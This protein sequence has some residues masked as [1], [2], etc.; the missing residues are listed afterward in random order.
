[1]PGFRLILLYT[2]LSILLSA[3]SAAE[4]CRSV[5]QLEQQ[6]AR[7]RYQTPIQQRVEQFNQFLTSLA[8]NQSC[9]QQTHY[10]IVEAMIRGSLLKGKTGISAFKQIKQLKMVLD[11]AI[12]QEPTAMQGMSWVLL[13][14]L[15]DKAPG[16]PFS[17]GGNKKAERAY[18]KGLSLNTGGIDVNY[19]YG[20]FLRRQQRNQE[21]K[22]HLL[23]ALNAKIQSGRE[24]AHQGRVQ[25]AK[26]ALAKLNR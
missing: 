13:G 5:L 22:N 8:D 17:I 24:L 25:D 4:Q 14:L 1:M 15:Y 12:K 11:Q 2:A 6:W 23:V 3:A 20:D 26:R 19:F 16:W 9:Y 21:A 7:I 10:L 18:L